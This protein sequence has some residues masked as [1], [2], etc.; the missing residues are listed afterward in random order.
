[1]ETLGTF[2]LAYLLGSIPFGLLVTR[3]AGLGDVRKVGSGN[4]GATNVL[5]TGHKGLAALTLLLDFGKGFAA[6]ILARLLYHCDYP[7][8]AGLFAVIGHVFPVWLR[9]K[10]GKGVAT[11]IGVLFA[12]N[13]LLAGIVCLTW[14]ALFA[15]TRFSSL[16]S[17]TSIGISGVIA[18]L[19]HDEMTS[20]LCL[21]LAAL[22]VFTHRANIQRLLAGTEPA[23]RKK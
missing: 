12:L 19:L 8:L 20:M 1:M 3:A 18:Y 17:I 2:A 10:G 7:T 13:P 6:V 5:R 22:I 4:I 11:A 16:S 21:A 15:A 14:L 9:F 23:F